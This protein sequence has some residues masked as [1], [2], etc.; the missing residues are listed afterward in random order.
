MSERL[1]IFVS[2]VLA[3]D[4]AQGGATWAVLQYVAG[5][6]RLGHGVRTR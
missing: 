6:R 5:L 1:R 3:G 4:S 2:G